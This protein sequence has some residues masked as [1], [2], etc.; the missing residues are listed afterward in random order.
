MHGQLWLLCSLFKTKFSSG[1]QSL[2]LK[3]YVMILGI[4]A[5]FIREIEITKFWLLQ[6]CLVDSCC[7]NGVLMV[8]WSKIMD[9]PPTP[10][11]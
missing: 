6:K 9:T 11:K 8:R 2:A 7:W 4:L 3:I 10:N 5:W 1:L